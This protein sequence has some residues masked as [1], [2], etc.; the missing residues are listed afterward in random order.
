MSSGKSDR[1]DAVATRQVEI[2]CNSHCSVRAA[3]QVHSGHCEV[4]TRSYG[5]LFLFSI[6]IGYG[7]LS[8]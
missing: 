2:A 4:P 6:L 7:L 1:V 3:A 8:Y 5:P